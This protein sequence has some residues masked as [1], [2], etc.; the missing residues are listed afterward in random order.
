MRE[1]SLSQLKK[2]VDFLLIEYTQL[3]AE[4]I[5]L[6]KMLFEGL[7]PLLTEEHLEN[8]RLNSYDALEARITEAL[9]QLDGVPQSEIQKKLMH[10]KIDLEQARKG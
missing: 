2:D 10:L 6:R 4:N 5:V 3:A 7:R 1:I 8:L 9:H